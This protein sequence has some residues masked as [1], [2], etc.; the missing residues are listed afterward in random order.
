MAEM[1]DYL[2]DSLVTH[3]FRTSSWSKPSVLAI[4][5]LTTNAIDADTGQF[6]TGTGVEV[7]SAGAY[8]RVERNPLDA[9]WAAATGGG[10]A[11]SNVAAITFTQS[12]GSWGTVAA[13]AIVD[14]STFD[15]GN[16]LFYSTVGTSRTIDSGDTAEFAI[17]AITVTFA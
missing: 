3:I 13:M 8:A 14:N 12:T 7:P 10:G 9:N 15:A 16:L 2:E 1:A 5:L 17:G 11:T 4:A 6:S